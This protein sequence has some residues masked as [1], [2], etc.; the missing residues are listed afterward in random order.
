MQPEL[1]TTK[2]ECETD[3]P[4]GVNLIPTRLDSDFLTILFCVTRLLVMTLCT[5]G[6]RESVYDK[7]IQMNQK[8]KTHFLLWRY[9]L[10]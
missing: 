3:I 6:R 2:L 10:F 8:T 5:T 1:R 4:K 9:S 7:Q